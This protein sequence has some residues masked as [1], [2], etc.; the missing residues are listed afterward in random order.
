MRNF[1]IK[2]QDTNE[3]AFYNL[4]PVEKL[5]KYEKYIPRQKKWHVTTNELSMYRKSQRF[6]TLLYPCG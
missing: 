5:W 6:Y 4:Y 2:K 3:T 1:K